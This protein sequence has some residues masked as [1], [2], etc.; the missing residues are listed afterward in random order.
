MPGMCRSWE[1][2]PQLVAIKVIEV[3]KIKESYVRKNLYREARILSQLRH[4]NIVR[5]FETLRAGTLYCLV[6]EYAAGGELLSYIRTQKDCRLSEQQAW[7][8]VRQLISALCYLHERGVVHRDLKMENILLDEKKKNIKIV[9]FGLSNSFTAEEML[10]THCGSPEYAAPELFTTGKTYGPEID[11]WSLGINM[12]ALLV[13]KLPFTAPFNDER[14]RQMLLQQIQ[15]GLCL[16]HDKEMAHLSPDCRSLLRQL[17]EPNPDY[18]LPMIEIEVHHWVTRSGACPFYPYQAPPRDRTLRTQVIEEVSGLMDLDPKEVEKKVHEYRSD[19][20]S[21][22]FNMMVEAQKKEQGFYDLD[23]TVKKTPKYQEQIMK[24]TLRSQFSSRLQFRDPKHGAVRTLAQAIAHPQIVRPKKESPSQCPVTVTVQGGSPAHTQVTLQTGS[25]GNTQATPIYLG[26]GLGQMGQSDASKTDQQKIKKPNNLQVSGE[27]QLNKSPSPLRGSLKKRT[28]LRVQN[29]DFMET[30]HSSPLMSPKSSQS[31]PPTPRSAKS[32]VHFSMDVDQINVPNSKTNKASSVCSPSLKKMSNGH[33]HNAWQDSRDGQT[34][35]GKGGD[36]HSHAREACKASGAIPKCSYF[37]HP[38]PFYTKPEKRPPGRPGFSHSPS[39]GRKRYTVPAPSSALSEKHSKEQLGPSQTNLP[40]DEKLKRA[41]SA[42]GNELTVKSNGKN[43]KISKNPATAIIN[44]KGNPH[45]EIHREHSEEGEEQDIEAELAAAFE[46]QISLE[47]DTVSNSFEDIETVEIDNIKGGMKTSSPNANE[48][49]K[50]T[51]RK[52][53]TK[54]FGR[55]ICM[56]PKPVLAIPIATAESL[57]ED[58]D[59]SHGG[60]SV[61]GKVKGVQK[62][63][64]SSRQSPQNKQKCSRAAVNSTP[65]ATVFTYPGD[66]KSPVPDLPI[67]LEPHDEDTSPSSP[68]LG[69]K[70][71]IERHAS[72]NCKT[73]TPTGSRDQDKTESPGRRFFK[74]HNNHP[75]HNSKKQQNDI[76]ECTQVAS[77]PEMSSPCNE[78]RGTK[79]Q[80]LFFLRQYDKAKKQITWR[81]GLSHLL[82]RKNRSNNNTPPSN[83]MRQSQSES[84]QVAKPPSPKKPHPKWQP[85]HYQEMEAR[86]TGAPSPSVTDKQSFEGSGYLTV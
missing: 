28:N 46:E 36:E 70:G 50:S 2:R 79:S 54:Y 83:H 82:R 29:P 31:T 25:T 21:A 10:K 66:L 32:Q 73:K 18:R 3:Q 37:S 84:M 45:Q 43:E 80:R 4:P 78:S 75:V 34:G 74:L 39:L 71:S 5:L 86:W 64:P 23:H 9:D 77:S 68:L 42:N 13:G 65:M 11:I 67:R 58:S 63:F 33:L 7:P 52:S 35:S 41:E 38:V 48:S 16:Q 40:D 26:N 44:T 22:M 12:Y 55:K 20:L 69:K 81:Q 49:S 56:K 17:I 62:L 57:S 14:R 24:H 61:T 30:M 6:T 53:P 8:Y 19:E 51:P 1:I 15:K 76:H 59:S 60:T 85:E 27:M 47:S 72:P